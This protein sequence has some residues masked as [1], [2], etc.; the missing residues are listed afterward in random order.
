MLSVFSSNKDPISTMQVSSNNRALHG[1]VR[2]NKKSN[3]YA[4]NSHTFLIYM[5]SCHLCFEEFAITCI[6]SFNI[7]S[8]KI[9][10]RQ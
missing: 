5:I 1:V 4:E 9:M 7:D 3:D 6:C 2:Q 8:K 10:S